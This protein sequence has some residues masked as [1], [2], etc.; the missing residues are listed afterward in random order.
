MSYSTDDDLYL[1]FGRDNVRKWADVNNRGDESEIDD[2]IEWAREEAH[3]ELN[4]RLARSPY[5]FPLTVAPTRF[6]KRMEA[7]LACMLLNESRSITDTEEDA[8]DLKNIAKRVERF[9]QGIKLG[10]IQLAGIVPAVAATEV[11]FAVNDFPDVK[12]PDEETDAWLD[13][14]WEIGS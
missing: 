8:G 2:R 13:S 11:P 9:I 7:T 6:V 10:T 12:M 14:F 4:A 5:Q 3:D 1:L